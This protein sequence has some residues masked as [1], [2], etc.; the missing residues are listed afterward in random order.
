V[1]A[2]CQKNLGTTRLIED[3]VVGYFRNKRPN[4][5]GLTRLAGTLAPPK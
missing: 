1:E 3:P 2:S 4:L 5:N